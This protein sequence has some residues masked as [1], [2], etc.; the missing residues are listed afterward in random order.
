MTTNGT[1]NTKY[2]E[3]LAYLMGVITATI[4][5]L[6]LF[7]YVGYKLGFSSVSN[8][9]YEL[10]I[11]RE[12]Y[13]RVL[14][15][16]DGVLNELQ[17]H[18]AVIG[19]AGNPLKTIKHDTVLVQPDDEFGYT[20]RPGVNLSLNL[21]RTTKPYNLDPPLLAIES[22]AALSQSVV[23]YIEKQSRMDFQYSTNEHGFRTTIPEMRSDKRVLVIGDSV[24]F[25][26]G[27]DDGNTM[28]S[29]LQRM[30]GETV[31][32]V[33]AGVGGYDGR[34]A[35][36]RAKQ[37]AESSDFLGLIYVA[38]Q[39]DFMSNEDWNAEAANVL[40]Q[41]KEISGQFNDNIIIVLETYMEYNLRDVL[42][43][44]NE[45]SQDRISK[46]SLLRKKTA[47]LSGDLG[48]LFSDWTNIVNRFMA[49]E[50]S[51]FSRFALYADHVHLSP[52]GNQLLAKEVLGLLR[53][54]GV[55]ASNG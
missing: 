18:R 24:A 9:L 19:N 48:F 37:L 39:N 10:V 35:V 40:A 51:I 55:G 31:E 42:L 46:T 28:A 3:T 41:L 38:C 25:G 21:L 45:W 43:E 50:K 47:E 34:K 15:L 33:N 16:P 32:V 52:L 49:N 4:V 30:L 8:Y 14:Y 26:V 36:A 20:L 13:E 27:V 53:R 17:A 2:N 1:I 54:Q 29:N 11:P 7:L 22:S 23:D 12:P 5:F 6:L 44:K